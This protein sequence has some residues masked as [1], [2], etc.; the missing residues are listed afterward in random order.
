MF[1]SQAQQLPLLATRWMTDEQLASTKVHGGLFSC[2]VCSRGRAEPRRLAR[3]REATVPRSPGAPCRRMCWL[4][5]NVGCFRARGWLNKT[6]KASTKPADPP[7][8]PHNG[9]RVVKPVRDP[10]FL[11]TLVT[12]VSRQPAVWC[13]SRPSSCFSKCNGRITRTCGGHS[14]PSTCSNT[15]NNNNPI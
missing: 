10:A 11:P 2:S 1:P 8:C 14:V 9:L 6:R 5:A 12:S 15:G 4:G 13:L 7:L 3:E